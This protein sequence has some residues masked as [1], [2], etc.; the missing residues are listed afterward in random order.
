MDDRPKE[1]QGHVVQVTFWIDAAGKV[2]RV[3]VAPDIHD[4][5]Y[6]R[7]FVEAMVNYRFRPARGPDGFPIA[8][9]YTIDFT[10]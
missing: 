3:A 9:T 6:S 7:K 2:L 4:R 8:S 5:G 1:L 10:L